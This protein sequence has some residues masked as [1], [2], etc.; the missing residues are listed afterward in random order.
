MYT[1]ANELGAAFLLA[2]RDQQAAVEERL[3]SEHPCLNAQSLE[4]IFCLIESQKTPSP[5]DLV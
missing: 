3:I 1:F 2:V 4:A 5:P